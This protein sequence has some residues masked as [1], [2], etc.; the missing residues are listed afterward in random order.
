MLKGVTFTTLNLLEL[1][2]LEIEI[3]H[4]GMEMA[5]FKIVTNTAGADWKSSFS[6]LD[7]WA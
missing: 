6:Q 2:C 1:I 4:F 5:M 3:L 7:F